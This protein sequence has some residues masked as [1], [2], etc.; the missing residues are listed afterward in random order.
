M[1]SESRAGFVVLW[2]DRRGELKIFKSIVVKTTAKSTIWFVY[3]S[4]F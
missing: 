3:Y 2:L 4:S 1:I